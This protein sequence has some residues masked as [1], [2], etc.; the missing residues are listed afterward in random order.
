MAKNNFLLVDL[1][2][3]KTQKL[4]ETITSE[5]S[6]KILNYL[7]EKDDSEANIAKELGIPISTVH[8]HLQKLVEAGLVVVE[9]FHYSKKG[10]EVNHYKLANKYIIIAPKKVSGLRQALKNVLP[11]GLIVL[12]ISAI[13]KVVQSFGNSFVGGEMMKAS[14]RSLADEAI[15][16]SAPVIN[17]Y[18]QEI[19]SKPDVA[20]WFFIGGVSAIGIY[21]LVMLIKEWWRRKS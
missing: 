8:Y 13:I 14:A 18:S 19:V 17:E 12:G 5:T 21:L 11:V 15:M 20:L 6:R 2:E 16:E 3:K 1:S 4:A 9:E 7:V 10:R